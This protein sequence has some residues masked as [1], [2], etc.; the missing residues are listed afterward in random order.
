MKE[1]YYIF[2]YDSGYDNLFTSFSTL[3]EVETY[4]RENSGGCPLENVRSAFTI[5]KGYELSYQPKLAFDWK[6]ED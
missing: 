6:D 2:E 5:I 4:I 1:M 3:E